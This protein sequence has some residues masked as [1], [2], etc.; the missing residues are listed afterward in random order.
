MW[1]RKLYGHLSGLSEMSGQCE[2]NWLISPFGPSAII[3][4]IIR[5]RKSISSAHAR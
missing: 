5:Q 1:K 2:P 4:R 3:P